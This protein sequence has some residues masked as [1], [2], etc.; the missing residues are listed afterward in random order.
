MAISLICSLFGYGAADNP[1]RRRLPNSGN[2][3][4]RNLSDAIDT[5]TADRTFQT[6]MS[7]A[8]ETWTLF[9]TGASDDT[10]LPFFHITMSFLYYI[11]HYRMAMSLI[12]DRLPW[13]VIAA[14]LNKCKSAKHRSAP[15]RRLPED[16]AMEGLF[17][18]S[19]GWISS[20]YCQ[21]V[22]EMSQEELEAEREWRVLCLGDDIAEL[23]WQLRWDEAAGRY[24]DMRDQR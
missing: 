10:N 18:S 17:L 5:P 3:P 20:A 24:K 15:P 19:S 8:V 9:L 13:T 6:A 23:G 14:R 7:F 2:A 1:L 21:D 11:A 12:T 22:T 16:Y 4:P